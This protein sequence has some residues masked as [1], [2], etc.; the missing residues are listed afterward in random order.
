MEGMDESTAIDMI[1]GDATNVVHAGRMEKY[2]RCRRTLSNDASLKHLRC[3]PMEK[4]A[5][6]LA[7][8]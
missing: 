6:N 2:G 3:H 7:S 5:E 8:R 4:E 1:I